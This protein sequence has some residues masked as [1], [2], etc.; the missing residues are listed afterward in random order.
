[1]DDWHAHWL[2]PALMV[3]LEQRLAPPRILRQGAETFLL[4]GTNPRRLHPAVHDLELRRVQ[5]RQAGISRQL[6]SLSSLWNIDNLPP[7]QSLPLVQAF[8]DATAQAVLAAPG[9][10]AGLAA[11]PL[12]DL[13]AAAGEL[14]RGISAG[15]KGAILPAEAFATLSSARRLGP[16]LACADALDAHLFIH[17]GRLLPA[18]PAGVEDNERARNIVLETQHQLSA[19]LLTLTSTKILHGYPHL[20]VQVANLGGAL[21]F[22]LE[23]LRA[24]AADDPQGSGWFFDARRVIVDCASF[25]PLAIGMAIDALGVDNVVLGTDMPLFDAARAVQGL[26]QAQARRPREGG[27]GSGLRLAVNQRW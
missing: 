13:D 23:R 26:G 14:Q 6:L 5:L 20:T 21:P 27:A 12:Q 11:L 2:P 10:F 25:G 18:N 9:T 17:P 7:A 15:L 19:A 24:V 3:L 4:T 8:N 16:L 1:M 22:L